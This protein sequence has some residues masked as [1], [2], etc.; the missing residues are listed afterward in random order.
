[1]AGD[2]IKIKEVVKGQLVDP[3]KEQN[4]EEQDGKE[5]EGN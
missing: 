4:K 3:K 1:M 5:K 2:G